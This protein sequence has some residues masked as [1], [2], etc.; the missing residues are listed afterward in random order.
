MQRKFIQHLFFSNT[1]FYLA[2]KTGAT[3]MNQNTDFSNDPATSDVDISTLARQFVLNL[4]NQ[5]N[6]TRLV[7]HSYRQ[8]NEIVKSVNSLAQANGSTE[9]EWEAAVL[10]GWF[11]NVG[12]L[13]DYQNPVGK[14]V[15]LAGKFLD[16]HHFTRAKKSLILGTISAVHEGHPAKTPEPQ[17]LSDAVNGVKYGAGFF[18]NLPLWQLERELVLN[19]KYEPLEW[20]AYAMEQLRASRFY[21][22]HAKVEYE[23]LMASH[24]VVLKQRIEKQKKR[25]QAKVEPADR[26][27]NNLEPRISTGVQTF[28]RTNYR[29][30]INLSAIADQKANI[31]ISVNAILISVIISVISYRNMTETNPAILMPVLIFLVTGLA[32]LIFA[33]LAARPKVTS[34]INDST[35]LEDAKKHL[36]FFGNF[37]SLNVDKYEELLEEMFQDTELLYGN[38]SR[39]LYY[40]GKVLDKKYR[41]LSISYNIFM[42]GFVATVL[43]FLGVLFS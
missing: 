18:E 4:F 8:A 11:F 10:A 23:P 31:M 22:S 28:F 12:Y 24:I 29:N 20:L 40:L 41:F 16:A 1:S 27:F 6:D 2:I 13:F 14:S 5:K 37:V 9:G 21:T 30:H 3:R 42:V 7:H 32:S 34:N 33:V 38:M 19:L 15:E 36:V 43:T 39:D 35:P 17:L 25:E 26:R